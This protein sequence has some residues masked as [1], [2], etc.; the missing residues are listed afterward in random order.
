[1]ILGDTCQPTGVPSSRG[2]R[3]LGHF[4][5][6]LPVTGG[7]PKDSRG[8]PTAP[9]SVAVILTTD[10]MHVKQKLLQMIVCTTPLQTHMARPTMV[11]SSIEAAAGGGPIGS[12]RQSGAHM[13]CGRSGRSRRPELL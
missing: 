2:I 1:V 10:R 9:R 13:R 12:A 6:S 4:V 8:K 7:E 11:G 3:V 5:P